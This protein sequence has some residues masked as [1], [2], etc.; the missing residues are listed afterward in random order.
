MHLEAE[1]P[2]LFLN[3]MTSMGETSLSTK[4]YA[5]E[6]LRTNR[7]LI[8]RSAVFGAGANLIAAAGAILRVAGRHDIRLF[9]T[10]NEA[11]AWLEEA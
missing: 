11:I 8:R 5:A 10:K 1:A 4:W 9:P 3:D 6:R 2:V 7:P